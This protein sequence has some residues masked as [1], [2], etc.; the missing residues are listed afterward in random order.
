[1]HIARRAK[2]AILAATA[3]TSAAAA[4][5][6]AQAS[7][8]DAAAYPATIEAP[9]AYAADHADQQNQAPAKRFAL[10]AVAAGALAGLIKLLGVKK[11]ARAAGETA[12]ATVRVA[13]RAA[14]SAGGAV[15]RAARSPLRFMAWMTVLALFALTG[16]ALYGVEWVG[17]LVAGAAI[18]G[19]GVYAIAKIRAGLAPKPAPVPVPSRSVN[20]N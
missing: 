17:G 14:A 20:G 15:M 8:Y 10:I 3:L 4:L 18:A 19:L 1:M 2:I 9:V 12:A 7:D 6:P 5:A 11:V 13:G 16:V